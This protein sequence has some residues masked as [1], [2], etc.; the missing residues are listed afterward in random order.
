[1]AISRVENT[2]ET[3]GVSNLNKLVTNPF[4]NT[5]FQSTP[6]KTNNKD[7]TNKEKV[8][9]DIQDANLS[10]DVKAGLVDILE[11]GSPSKD[12]IDMLIARY[13]EKSQ[14]FE[15]AWAEYQA[16]KD[17]VKLARR[18]LEVALKRY[19]GTES[20]FE[21]GLVE[22]AN[23]DFKDAEVCA[24]TKLDVAGMISHKLV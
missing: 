1:M 8:Y 9:L 15:V 18:L 7:M 24:D 10:A 20:T 19:D 16:A 4:I 13:E 21:Q 22:K 23:R 3:K 5:V 11:N 2:Q 12:F 6:K 14:E 17:N